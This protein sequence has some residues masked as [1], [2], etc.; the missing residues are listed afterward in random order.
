MKL[1]SKYK[2]HREIKI[3][4]NEFTEITGK[5]LHCNEFDEED[6][7]VQ[8]SKELELYEFTKMHATLDQSIK[9]KKRLLKK[10]TYLW[11]TGLTS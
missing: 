3:E 10:C 8:K 4:K 11:T 1:K 9:K 6:E 2:I 5:Y 7:L